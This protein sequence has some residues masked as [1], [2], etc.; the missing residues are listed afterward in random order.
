MYGFKD[1]VTM[2]LFY[3]QPGVYT[4]Y[5]Y[6]DFTL[7]NRFNQFNHITTDR[8]GTPLAALSAAHANRPNP[9]IYAEA[10]SSQ[11]NKAMYVQSATGIQGKIRFPSLNTVLALPGYLGILRAQLILKP[12]VGTFS[13]ELGLPPQIMLSQTDANNQLGSPIFSGSGVEYGNLFIDYSGSGT[14]A[15]SY[16]ITS[17]IKQQ[18]TIGGN[19]TDGLMLSLPSPA[20][21]TIFNRAVFG[22]ATNKNYNVTLNLYY[23]SLPHQ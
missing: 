17:Y 7:Y 11:M 18:L 12:I 13:P 2:R 1:T 22:D 9:Q 14:T 4:T 16:D 5:N 6:V 15:Y 21:Y 10:P 20:S 23:I 3:H 19:N 8:T